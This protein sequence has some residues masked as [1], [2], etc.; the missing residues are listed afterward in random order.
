MVRKI[1]N[2]KHEGHYTDAFELYK[3]TKYLDNIYGK[4]NVKTIA[5]SYMGHYYADIY[6]KNGAKK[7][8]KLKE[9]FG[10]MMTFRKIGKK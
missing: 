6:V 7:V 2:Y 4:D 9:K 1:K 5:N 10:S 3:T 8:A